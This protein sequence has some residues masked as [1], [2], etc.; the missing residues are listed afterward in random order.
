M[1][2]ITIKGI[3]YIY[4]AHPRT[5]SQATGQAIIAMGGKKVG[6]HH[7][8]TKTRPFPIN[9]VLLTT[10]RNPYDVAVSWVF[11][12]HKGTTYPEKIPLNHFKEA[13]ENN[14]WVIT[15]SNNP[16]FWHTRKR[17]VH[18]VRYESLQS[19]LEAIFPSIELPEISRSPRF[20]R[21]YSN[22]YTDETRDY[23]TD[24]FGV[25]CRRFGYEF[26]EADPD[27]NG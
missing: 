18:I 24:L 25:E 22:F 16:I 12:R 20:G 4:L 8:G 19:D 13:L 9:S 14:R 2:Q 17:G 23:V 15:G 5:A 7:G 6:S 10:V 1:Y 26:E 3:S 21:H 11:G 27:G